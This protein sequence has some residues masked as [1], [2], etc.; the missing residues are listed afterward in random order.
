MNKNYFIKLF[1]ICT[2]FIFCLPT[3]AQNTS[4]D[5]HASD[6]SK[7]LN[8]VVISGNRF[9]E[10]R[11]N[12]PQQILRI[13]ATEVKNTNAPTAAEL[14][15]ASGKV[16][17]QKS[18][19]GGGSPVLRGFEAS[20]VL[21]VLDGVRLNNAIY[22]AG[23]LQNVL[24]I[25]Q[26]QLDRIEVVYGPSSV[27]YGSDALGGVLHFITRRPAL[28][29]NDGLKLN[30]QAYA[31]YGTAA[32]ELT[33]NANFNY[34]AKK[35]AGITSATV[36]SFDDLRQG[37][38]ANFLS[39]NANDSLWAC[40][41]YAARINDVDTTLINDDPLRQI[42]SGYKQYNFTQ[43]FRIQANEQI[44]HNFQV[45]YSTTN[46][47]PRYDRLSE[48]KGGLPRRAVW[49]Y[50][51]EKALL[52]NYQ[53]RAVQVGFAD[54]TAFT[55]SYQNIKE[56]RHD[57]NFNSSFQNNRNENV[58]VIFADADAKK[59]LGTHTLSFGLE[60]AWNDV[61]STANK[62][63]VKTGEV[64][65]QSTRYPSGGSQYTSAAAY[66][67]DHWRL[68]DNWRLQGGL[69]YTIT[70]IKANFDDTTF[71]KLDVGEVKQ[72]NGALSGSLGLV[73]NTQNG[74]HIAGL[75][76]TG[77][78]VP[79]IDDMGKVFD[80][81]PGAVVVPNPDIKPEYTKNF[82]LNLRKTINNKFDVEVV[83]F[84]TLLTNA[85]N[86]AP[87]TFNGQD[88]IMYDDVMSVVTANQN[89]QKGYV[90]GTSWALAWQFADQWRFNTMLSTT[91]GRVKRKEATDFV[92]LDHVA[93]LFGKT[94][95]SW[96]TRDKK[97]NT[98]FYM[99]YNGWKHIEDYN[100]YGEDNEESA[101]AEGMP[102]WMTFNLRASYQLLKALELQ[103]GIE[104]LLDTRYR[105]F[106][107]G[108]S[109]PGRNIVVCLRT[110]F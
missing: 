52:A 102:A 73:Y 99:L 76:S 15:T 24:R 11:R 79:N 51:P 16:F 17:V 48:R 14:L 100:P 31:R 19:L 46:N 34:G 97:L 64:Q 47:I 2:L 3:K 65:P 29:Q 94:E 108:I 74:W 86:T 13:D 75:F 56:S 91:Y 43:K 63:H 60:A 103:V 70:Q 25:D 71:Y 106:A 27:A 85:I 50:G 110:D 5:K 80:S 59:T 32:N 39:K 92:P 45:Y 77:F 109:A 107:S 104:N 105:H 21:L 87:F 12:L 49:Y 41:D 89:A 66:A 42:A 101:T 68:S 62:V 57:R 67:F 1:I 72:N 38:N 54:E 26:N 83:G 8:E 88:S 78:R 96:N 30:G 20:R 93:P 10:E 28:N 4:S 9:A 81:E 95:I 7:M 53:F 61:R 55:L 84:Y 35:W 82:E 69:R 6:T 44:S 37:K 36:S 23:H 18:Q 58:K 90:Y 40:Y 22:R 33:V 98:A